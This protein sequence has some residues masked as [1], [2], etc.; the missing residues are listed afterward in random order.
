[1]KNKLNKNVSVVLDP[2]L[3]LD[4]DD[5]LKVIDAQ[6]LTLPNQQGIYTYILDADGWKDQVINQVADSLKEEVFNNQPKAII[7]KQSNNLDDHILPSIEC[8]IKGFFD[9][10]FVITDSFHGTVFSI[11]FNKPF[12]SLLNPD[13]GA[14]RFYSILSEFGLEDRLVNEYDEAKI[15]ALLCQGIN[16]QQVNEKLEQLKQSSKGLLEEWLEI[17][18]STFK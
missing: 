16:Y 13:R 9:A 14:S 5:Y 3:L 6:E 7:E 18:N 11:L 17:K 2:T 8:W 15:N 12:V 4:K 10:E 1:V